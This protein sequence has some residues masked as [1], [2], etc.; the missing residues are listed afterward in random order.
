MEDDLA[1]RDAFVKAG[2]SYNEHGGFYLPGKAKSLEDK[3]ARIVLSIYVG[4]ALFSN[5][6][7]QFG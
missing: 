1:I 7:N 6:L 5:L 2:Y 4:A 3:A